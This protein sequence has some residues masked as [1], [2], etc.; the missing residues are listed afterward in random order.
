MGLYQNSRVIWTITL[1]LFATP[2][3][4]AAPARS[5]GAYTEAIC[6][7][8]DVFFCEDFDAS[9]DSQN[10][11][12]T[13]NANTC[14]NQWLNPALGDPPAPLTNPWDMCF[15][16]GGGHQRSTI[17]LPGFN[18]S[19]NYVWRIYKDGS[20]A[21]DLKTGVNSDTGGGT[22]AGW[23]DTSILGTGAREWYCRFQIYFHSSHTWPNDYDFKMPCWGLPREFVDPPSAEYENGIFAHQDF[24]CNPPN[25]SYNDV[26]VLRYS[27]N[28]AQFPYQNEYCP[29]LSPGVDAN[30]TNAPR[31]EKGRWY[32]IEAHFKLGTTAGTGKMEMWLD[33][34]LAYT[35]DRA[36]CTGDCPDLGYIMIMGWMNGADTQTGFVEF[37][38]IVYSRAPI[39]VPS[40]D[41]TPPDPPTNL[42]IQ[43][44]ML[45]F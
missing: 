14:N 1:M 40:A 32:T 28:F 38:N 8:T 2:A 7:S 11:Y 16:N 26:P 23:L 27:N 20:G 43:Q 15:P 3:W 4:A 31:L 29:P 17:E 45:A 19:T 25:Q 12:L 9:H 5:Q 39:G 33:G 10:P 34:N 36:T 21:T 13:N 41:S 30:G 6:N 24:F 22:F 44:A 37:D 18:Q 42:S 35:E